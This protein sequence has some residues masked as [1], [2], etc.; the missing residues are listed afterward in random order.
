MSTDSFV[1]E[2]FIFYEFVDFIYLWYKLYKLILI[3]GTEDLFSSSPG[4]RLNQSYGQSPPANQNSTN[5][6]SQVDYYLNGPTIRMKCND[7]TYILE[8]CPQRELAAVYQKILDKV[9]DVRNGGRGFNVGYV[10]RSREPEDFRALHNFLA[11]NGPMLRTSAKLLSDPYLRFDF[12]ISLLSSFTQQQIETMTATQFIAS[13][14]SPHNASNLLLNSFEYYMF[15]FAT[16]LVKPYTIDN[17]IQTGDSLYTTLAEEYLAY[18]LPCDGTTPPLLP[19]TVSFNSS[20]PAPSSPIDRNSAVSSASSPQTPGRKSLL[21][22]SCSSFLSSPSSSKPAPQ[23][24]SSPDLANQHQLNGNGQQVYRSES[25]IYT[26]FE[27]WLS[28]FCQATK[29]RTDS[30]LSQKSVDILI[31]VSDTLRIIRM[32]IKHMHYFVNSG[33]PLDVSHLCQLKRTILLN[34]KGRVYSLF[35]FIFLHWPHDMSFR[36][37]LETWLSYIQPW[38]YTDIATNNRY[39]W[40]GN[41]GVSFSGF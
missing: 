12:P 38:R 35:K 9:F 21:R 5:I 32:L 29:C 23:V 25:M 27:L 19:S 7:L 1:L 20:P 17:K 30:P 33:G 40:N 31:P 10:L 36:L 26:F 15:T 13:K 8:H 2:L 3:S 34:V 18:F 6:L 28:P 4:S 39:K 14:L 37:V 22:S 24:Y 16:Y 11:C 41:K